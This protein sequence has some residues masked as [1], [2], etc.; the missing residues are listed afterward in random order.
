[1]AKAIHKGFV[2]LMK[3]KEPGRLRRLLV[4]IR[5]RV[6]RHGTKADSDQRMVDVGGEESLALTNVH[7][8]LGHPSV[9]DLQRFLRGAGATQEMIEATAWLR[10]SACAKTARPR[11][12]RSV[13]IPPQRYTVQ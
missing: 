5:K 4:A 12:H 9:Q 7:A 1:M 6:G 10:C 8:N 13:R 11:T 2:E 3:R